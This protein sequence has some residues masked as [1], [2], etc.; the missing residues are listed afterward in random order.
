MSQTIT[1]EGMSCE[2]CEQTVEAALEDVDG[3]TTVDV[4]RDAERVTVDG[5]VAPQVLVDAVDEAGYD[6]S[7]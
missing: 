5:D 2:H 3:V 1:V 4:D 7:A 6:A